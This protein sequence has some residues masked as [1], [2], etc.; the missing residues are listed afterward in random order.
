MA[1]KHVSTLAAITAAVAFAQPAL[2]DKPR[3]CHNGQTLSVAGPSVPSHIAHGDTRGPCPPPPVSVA[4]MR[5][6]SIDGDIMVV[7][8]SASDDPEVT[9]RPLPVLEGATC[10]TA[11]AG[12]LNSGWELRFVTSGSSVVPAEG[13]SGFVTE[14]TFVTKPPYSAGTPK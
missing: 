12:F 5:C 10:A 6:D 4:L 7:G 2:A 8:G 11:V 13:E 9:P 14:Y 3:V 1:I